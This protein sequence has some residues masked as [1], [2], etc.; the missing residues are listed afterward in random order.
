M[1]VHIPT[2]FGSLLLKIVPDVAY[3]PVI[4]GVP[5]VVGVPSVASVLPIVP[6][7]SNVNDIE[8]KAKT[9]RYRSI[10]SERKQNV[11]IWSA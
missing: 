5:S 1:G 10:L 9:L 7:T 2:S 4:A 11:L 3:V 6:I 8:T